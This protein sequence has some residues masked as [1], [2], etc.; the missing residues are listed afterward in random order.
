MYDLK[1]KDQKENQFFFHTKFQDYISP[2]S[3][4]LNTHSISNHL[5]VI[6]SGTTS[7]KIK[8]Y[9]LSFSALT[10]SAKFV[11]QA[12]NIGT[13]DN[14]G[15]CLPPYHIGGLSVYARS[16]LLGKAPI[17]LHPWNPEILREK[18]IEENVTV[19]SL[20]PTQIYDLVSM[21]IIAPSSLKAVL[22]GG[23]FLSE[24]LELKAKDLNWPLVRSFGMTEVGSSLAIAGDMKNGLKILPHHQ[25]KIDSNNKLWVRSQSLYTCE[26]I[27]DDGWELKMSRSDIDQEGFFPLPDLAQS[28]TQG[29]IPLGRDDGSFKSSGRLIGMTHLKNILDSLMLNHQ[30]WGQMD[31]ISIADERK[32]KVLSLIYEDTI[33]QDIIKELDG[34]LHPIKIESKIKV[35]KIDKTELGKTRRAHI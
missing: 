12:L 1:I 30:C 7:N 17:I 5:C 28:G 2:L 18:I 4:L 11:N 21:K 9:A 29:I 10:I 20:V 3:S 8:G 25:I 24:E 33:S 6:S 15:L 32:G 31:L 14:W 22:V 34:L 16:M 35:K 26:F 19:I 23:D 27:L 13:N